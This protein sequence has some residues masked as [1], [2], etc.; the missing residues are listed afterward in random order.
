M[1]GLWAQILLFRCCLCLHYCRH[2]RGWCSSIWRSSTAKLFH[3]GSSQHYIQPEK[4]RPEGLPAAQDTMPM[5]CRSPRI[6]KTALSR[7]RPRREV[8]VVS[9]PSISLILSKGDRTMTVETRAKT[10][11]SRWLTPLQPTGKGFNAFKTT[12][13]SHVIWLFKT[14]NSISSKAYID[15]KSEK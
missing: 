6:R 10:A 12:F 9:A 15:R 2:P 13:S 11:T 3:F 14:E 7:H 5:R 1:Q 4:K 8:S